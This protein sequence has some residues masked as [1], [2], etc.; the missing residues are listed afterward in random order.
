MIFERTKNLIGIDKFS[1]LQNATVVVVGVGGVGGF[2][3][4]FL[5]R[6]G[7]GSIVIIDYD[8]IDITN[9]NRQII[10]TTKNV[11]CYKV[12]ELKQR[13][14]D[15]NPNLKIDAICDKLTKDN[16]AKYIT[17]NVSYVVD[18]I[19]DISNKVELICYCKE[20]NY[21][22]VSSMGVG[23][24]YKYTTYQITDIYK[25]EQDKL[26]KVLRKKL[27]DRAIKSLYVVSSKDRPEEIKDGIQSISYLPPMCASV[28]S[29]F[30][31]NRL[32]DD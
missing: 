29:C 7:V 8:K 22:I 28:L 15:I 32:I 30:V 27:K 17:E 14:L 10:A 11:G 21:N 25:T 4:E 24:R 2:T 5:V 31:V 20:K 12:L 19:D 23:N 9:I 26:A 18:C 3:A 6:A 13:L 16:I 1:K